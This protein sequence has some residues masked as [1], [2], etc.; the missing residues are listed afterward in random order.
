MRKFLNTV[1]TGANAMALRAYAAIHNQRG[2]FYISDA[3]RV[4]IAVVLGALL[5]AAITLIFN[6]TVIPGITEAIEDLF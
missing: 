5:L 6:D 4:I 1:K 3:V 2:D